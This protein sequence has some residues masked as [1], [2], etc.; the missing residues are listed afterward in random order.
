MVF[1]DAFCKFFLV[2]V[3]QERARRRHEELQAQG[4]TITL[5]EILQQIEERD[6]RDEQRTVAPLKPADDAIEINT[7]D[8]AINEVL[9]QLEQIVRSRI[10]S[11]SH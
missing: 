7:S 4:K 1:P 5:E 6:K 2:A 11:T 9:N 8:L 3:P 10:S